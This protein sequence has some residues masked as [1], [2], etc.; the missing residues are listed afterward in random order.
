MSITL[1]NVRSIIGGGGVSLLASPVPLQ[2]AM[3]SDESIRAKVPIVMEA[4]SYKFERDV[5]SDFSTATVIQNTSSTELIDTGLAVDTLYYYKVTVIGTGKESL[6]ITGSKRTL[7]FNPK[8]WF[9]AEGSRAGV[10][11]AYAN[12]NG[13]TTS[14][15][16]LSWKSIM[17]DP[18]T[19]TLGN[20]NTLNKIDFASGSNNEAKSDTASRYIRLAAN[21]DSPLDVPVTATGDFT[22]YFKTEHPNF[23]RTLISDIPSDSSIVFNTTKNLRVKIGGILYAVNFPLDI[24][25]KILYDFVIRRTG[26]L[27]EMSQDAGVTWITMSASCSTADWVLNTFKQDA[28]PEGSRYVGAVARLV[29]VNE[30]LADSQLLEI[31]DYLYGDPVTTPVLD[32]ATLNLDTGLSYSASTGETIDNRLSVE[33]GMTRRTWHCFNYGDYTVTNIATNG[34]LASDFYL[35]IIRVHKHSTNESALIEMPLL[36]DASAANERHLVGGVFEFNGGLF[37]YELNAWYDGSNGTDEDNKILFRQFAKG[38]NNSIDLTNLDLPQTFNGLGD[39]F[40]AGQGYQGFFELGQRRHVI[41]NGFAPTF[42]MRYLYHSYCDDY[43]SAWKYSRLLDTETIGRWCYPFYFPQPRAN[44][45]IL[46]GINMWLQGTD[47]IESYLF[48]TNGIEVR[49]FGRTFSKTLGDKNWLTNAE[50]VANFQLDA[51]VVPGSGAGSVRMG[52]AHIDEN[53]ELYLIAGNN[54]NQGQFTFWYGTPGGSMTSKSIDFGGRAMVSCETS[55]GEGGYVIK[56]ST[57]NYDVYLLAIEVGVWQVWKFST[58]DKG[59][60]WTDEGRQSTDVTKPH[61]FLAG[62]ANGTD[63]DY[64]TLTYKRIESGGVNHE[65]DWASDI[66]DDIT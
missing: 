3:L 21:T 52:S 60:T 7:S 38:A 51:Q 1:I 24:P 48:E 25:T 39:G 61:Q 57:N 40:L 26:T 9:E 11:N 34:Q 18:R 20:S 66:Y 16:L 15:T 65:I 50:L 64:L 29:L 49:N 13:G 44:D 47:F 43:L 54:T 17:G 63:A 41:S 46:M 37:H 22:F 8:F 62:T 59:N 31:R 19:I 5:N 28:Y 27:L 42:G 14:F 33:N 30:A 55:G 53:G 56:R 45:Y 32:K 10:D 58:T 12:A 6:P 36:P 23:F 35:D 2:L 4:D